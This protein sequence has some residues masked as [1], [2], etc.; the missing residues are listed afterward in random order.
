[1]V[2]MVPHLYVHDRVSLYAITPKHVFFIPYLKK[3]KTNL[4]IKK[5]N[6]V[7]VKICYLSLHCRAW[8]Y[9]HVWVSTEVYPCIGIVIYG[10]DLSPQP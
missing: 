9:A 1:M 3:Q 2:V 7:R 10:D 8:W 6:K 5:K 4:T